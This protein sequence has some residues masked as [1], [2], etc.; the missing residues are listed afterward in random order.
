MA[1]LGLAG[2]TVAAA[3]VGASAVGRPAGP[4]VTVV[5]LG[6]AD[7]G[8][9]IVD[10]SE[11]G[12]VAFNDPATGVF[13]AWRWYRGEAVPL[14]PGVAPGVSSYA[15]AVADDG[16]VVGFTFDTSGPEPMHGFVWRDGVTTWIAD[17]PGDTVASDIDDHG[18]VLV[19]RAPNGIGSGSR[20]SVLAGGRE[21]TSP[22]VLDGAW[23]SGLALGGHGQVIGDA[24][25]AATGA[26]GTFVWRPGR[27]PVDLGDLGGG[28]ATAS[29][30]NGSGTI[31]GSSITAGGELRMFRWRHGRMTDLGTLGGPNTRLGAST[32]GRTDLLN[33]RGQVAGT[34]ETATGDLHAFRWTDGRM[35]DLGTLGG[36]TSYAFGINDRGDVVGMSQRAS[37][38]MSAF[39]WRD[40]VM[41]DIGAATGGPG[42]IATAVNDRGDVL[43][44][45]YAD[46]FYA[47]LWSTRPRR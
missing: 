43:G 32:I 30:I 21:V 14:T 13:R 10:L 25:S 8:R 37:G 18:R 15:T 5:D 2:T 23:L 35:R 33:E 6:G 29:E 16:D 11:R 27:A 7:S 40:G 41:T 9:G 42:S 22:L 4:P 46:D 45:R 26:H 3:P 47:V 24:Y 31:I 19:N 20:A 12:H 44:V 17:G 1:C 34:S 38:E 28:Y 36:D 39:L